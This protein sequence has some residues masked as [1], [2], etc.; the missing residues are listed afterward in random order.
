[1]RCLYQAEDDPEPVIEALVQLSNLTTFSAAQREQAEEWLAR[2]N[3]NLEALHEVTDGVTL[4]VRGS[5]RTPSE[6]G[7]DGALGAAGGSIGASTAAAGLGDDDEGSTR[8]ASGVS[9]SSATSGLRRSARTSM[10]VP[11]VSCVQ[12]RVFVGVSRMEGSGS[13]SGYGMSDER[14]YWMMT[15]ERDRRRAVRRGILELEL[16]GYMC[17]WLF[18]TVFVFSSSIRK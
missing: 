1:M 3:T 15:V 16:F 18:E 6:N 10:L 17:V 11:A 5:P 9:G 4:G 8:T 7:T 13:G 2:V 12:Q 14:L